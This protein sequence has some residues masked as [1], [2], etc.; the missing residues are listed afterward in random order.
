M[1]YISKATV[2][3]GKIEIR[4]FR[5]GEQAAF[6]QE[7]IAEGWDIDVALKELEKRIDAFVKADSKLIDKKDRELVLQTMASALD[8]RAWE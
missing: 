6:W 3:D 5:D 7:E 1:S 4:L 2:I 8:G